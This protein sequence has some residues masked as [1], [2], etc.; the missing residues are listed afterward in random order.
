MPFVI[1]QDSH[2]KQ[3]GLSMRQV[4]LASLLVLTWVQPASAIDWTR[5]CAAISDFA[6][7]VASER[8][9]QKPA[10]AASDRVREILNNPTILTPEIADEVTH[11]VYATPSLSPELEAKQVHAKCLSPVQNQPQQ[12]SIA[13]QTIRSNPVIA[14]LTPI[15]LDVGINALITGL[16]SLTIG[17]AWED[18]D[19]RHGHD[20]F[21]VTMSDGSRVIMP[22]GDQ[23]LGDDPADDTYMRRSIRFARGEIDGEDAVL[24][25]MA[26]RD[27]GRKAT[28]TMFRV[29]RL[30]GDGTQYR[31]L[32]ISERALPFATCN[33]DAALSRA[34]GLPLRPSYRGA[35]TANG[36][37]A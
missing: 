5:T 9:T 19:K 29:Y 31:F 4:G 28:P 1:G 8:D 17:L 3:I 11:Q 7:L 25:L 15:K 36:C 21:T 30:V 27:P 26:E 34:S 33:A 35:A 24:L 14:G 37:P 23:V 2:S 12:T 10:S 18:I 13:T 32:L 16:G 20:V 6:A 22:D